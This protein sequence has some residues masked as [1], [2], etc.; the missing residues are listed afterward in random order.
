MAANTNMLIPSHTTWRI[1][2]PLSSRQIVISPQPLNSDAS[3]SK[4]GS[5]SGSSQAATR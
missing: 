4:K 3:G 5:R 1:P 2:K